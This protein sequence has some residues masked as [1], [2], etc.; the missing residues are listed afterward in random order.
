MVVK[1]KLVRKRYIIIKID[2]DYD[3]S[4]RDL[5]YTLNKL[6]ASHSQSSVKSGK[7]HTANTNDKEQANKRQ[8]QKNNLNILIN[9]T[10][11]SNVTTGSS[12]PTLKPIP[13]VPWVISL[14]N[15]IGLIRCHHLDKQKT[16]ELLQSITWI[17]NKKNLAKVETI[18]TTGT[19]QSARKKYLDKL[20][21][22][23]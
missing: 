23:P 4:K 8:T 19:I 5:I 6:T 21:L 16:I 1:S 22:Y 2:T 18:G 9:N 17:G 11:K 10:D 12:R 13:R 20:I 14:T 7:S 3:I 15:K